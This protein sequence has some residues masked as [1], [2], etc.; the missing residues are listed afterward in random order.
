MDPG[1]SF[2]ILVIWLGLKKTNKQ[3]K[4]R[5]EAVFIAKRKEI[6]R[7]KCFSILG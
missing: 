3:Q 5:K 7:S 1:S 6:Y 4:Q 2:A